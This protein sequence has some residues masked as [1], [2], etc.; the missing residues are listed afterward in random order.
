MSI[1]SF[2]KKHA[3]KSF[4][5]FLRLYYR[6]YRRKHP[7]TEEQKQAAAERIQA[8]MTKAMQYLPYYQ[9][10]LSCEILSDRLDYIRTGDRN[11]FLDRAEKTGMKFHDM[12]YSAGLNYTGI[13]L[14]YDQEDNDFRYTQRV[15]SSCGW[16]DKYRLMTLNE[17]LEG[18]E[19][20]DRELISPFLTEKGQFKFTARLITRNIKADVVSDAVLTLTRED[21]QYF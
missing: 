7:V 12:S 15:L 21:L 16:S 2:I 4:I 17:F 3:P 18:A 19:I 6:T 1:K 11:I 8:V 14:L 13:V 10:E 5:P 20:S 9:D